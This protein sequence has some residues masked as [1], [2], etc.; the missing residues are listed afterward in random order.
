MGFHKVQQ[1]S[2]PVAY[3]VNDTSIPEPERGYLAQ[4]AE[5]AAHQD[6][7]DDR[8]PY[9]RNLSIAFTAIATAF[10]GLRFF[11]RYRQ[12][13]RIGVDDWLILASMAI[14]VGNM[15]MN[16]VLIDQGLGLHS[17]ALTLTELQR[18]GQVRPPSCRWK[19]A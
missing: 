17:G 1:V 13:A 19:A 10:V 15:A 5:F 2:T 6:M 4:L 16:L 12:A 9:V 18:L 7:S 8:R 14:L 3:P 11:A